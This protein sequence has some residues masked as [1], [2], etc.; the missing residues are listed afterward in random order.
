VSPR[1]ARGL[2]LRRRAGQQLHLVSGAPW[3]DAL[4]AYQSDP[5]V[6]VWATPDTYRRGDLL[7]TVLSTPGMRMLLCLERAATDA[8]T[9]RRMNLIDVSA[10][11]E[12]TDQLIPVPAV[13]RRLG[14]RIPR[15]PASI[16]DPARADEL[17]AAIADELANPTPWSVFE[18][19][20]RSSTTRVRSAA[21]RAACLAA[22]G[23]VCSACDRDFAAL[24]D[25][26][27]ECALEVHHL[28]P[29][30]NRPNDTVETMLNE[31]VALCAA[32]HRI[33]HS[34]AQPS[35][36]QLRDAWAGA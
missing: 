5:G 20:R 15:A 10:W 17:L 2:T 29:L 31:V 32:C 22:A 16:L 11:D 36:A 23:G 34:P 35:L 19:Q 12:F 1:N 24:L 4:R 9:A 7:L 13:E 21:M 25:G 27:G 18:G 33:A 30:A 6:P 28:R 8:R 14:W 26:A 3:R